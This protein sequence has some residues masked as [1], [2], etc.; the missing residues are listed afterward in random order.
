MGC[1]YNDLNGSGVRSGKNTWEGIEEPQ[2]SG[3]TIRL[4]NSDWEKVGETVTNPYF[5]FNNVLEKGTYYLC[6]VM[7]DGWRQTEP[8][9]GENYGYT[10]VINQSGDSSE[11]GLCKQVTVNN[12]GFY[13]SHYYSFGNLRADAKLTISRSN[14]AASPLTPGSSVKHTITI[15]VEDNNINNLKLTDLLPYGFTFRAGSY[16]VFKGSDDITGSI[17]APEYHS[18]GVWNLGNYSKGD[19]IIIEYLADISSD[20][21][22]GYYPDLAW[23]V[24]N[25]AYNQGLTFYATGK[26]SE[27][28]S[29]DTYFVG[30][31]VEV[32]KD[33]TNGGTYEV[34]KTEGQVLG[35][36]TSLPA[37]GASPIWLMVAFICLVY[38]IR[39]IKSSNKK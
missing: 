36:S 2:L 3:W 7:Q 28:I 38:G 4:Y 21:N 8:L 33:Q 12:S 25:D 31:D 30:T 23:A 5:Y 37:T 35:A 26:N 17:T 19:E 18:P 27:Y 39:F 13:G 14:N 15:K 6:E 10:A 29:S 20:I 24:A 22:P 16:S 1:K 11:G 34:E 32:V 9:S